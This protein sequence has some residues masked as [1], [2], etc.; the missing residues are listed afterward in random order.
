MFSLTQPN[1]STIA[2]FLA[3]SKNLPLSYTPIGLAQSSARGF[4]LDEARIELGV[5]E[6]VFAHA[7]QALR[8]WRQFDLGWTEIVP[9][10]ASTEVGT[11][12][13][14]LV[15]HLGFWS[16]NGCRVVATL[17]SDVDTERFGYVYG[18]LT[19]HAER[20]EEI[21]AVT[22]DL[23]TGRVGY[24]LRAASHPRAWLAWCGY[25]V[26]RSLQTRFRRDSCAAMK[27]AVERG[28]SS[29]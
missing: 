28:E 3:E 20:G 27:R 8:E 17:E 4:V 12:V 25:P 11:V 24:E 14:V 18:T 1:A 10:G 19:N 9:R 29:K 23:R 13:A 5:G 21:F 26:T 7:C 15:R 2:R 6:A 16:L 22:R